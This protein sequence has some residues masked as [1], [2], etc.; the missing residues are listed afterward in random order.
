[1]GKS[2]VV[3]EALARAAESGPL[4]PATINFSAQTSSLEVQLLMEGR[5]EKKR[6]T[7]WAGAHCGGGLACVGW[8]TGRGG[9]LG[10]VWWVGHARRWVVVSRLLLGTLAPCMHSSFLGTPQ[11]LDAT[12][13]AA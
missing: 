4:L 6:K 3:A 12:Q 11:A 9:W 5:L 8:V 10:R 7:R 1:V 2:V 13:P